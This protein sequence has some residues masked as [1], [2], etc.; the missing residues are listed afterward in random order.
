MPGNKKPRK[1]KRDFDSQLA[2]GA[3][4]RQQRYALLNENV[5]RKNE[6]P[7]GHPLNAHRLDKTFGPIER[8]LDE[9]EKTG[10]N[11]ADEDGQ[12]VMHDPEEGW[13]PLVPGLLHM[14]H[15][16]DMIGRART[17]PVQ[18]PGLRAYALGL[19]IGRTITAEDL[20]DSRATIAWMR[21][22]IATLSPVTWSELFEWA[23]TQ[24]EKDWGK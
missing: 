13:V 21:K 8:V 17:W 23:C 15:I 10:T 16:F 5:R 9:A 19:Q 18:P 7:M 22:H 20:A 1:P 4:Q 24:D 11:L 3:R 6:L 12:P 14:C 2:N